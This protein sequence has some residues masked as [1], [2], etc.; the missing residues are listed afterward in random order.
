MFD[1]LYSSIDQ[2]TNLVGQLFGADVQVKLEVTPTQ[3]GSL[4]YGVFATGI[5]TSL[6]YG[7]NLNST[8]FRQDAMRGHLLVVFKRCT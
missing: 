8:V 4:D 5:C 2:A 1:S 6:A 3:L 7:Q